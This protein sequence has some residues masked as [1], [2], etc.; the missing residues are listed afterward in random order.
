MTRPRSDGRCCG[1]LVGWMLQLGSFATRG[2]SEGRNGRDAEYSSRQ[3]HAA[4]NRA[5]LPIMS[6]LRADQTR[7]TMPAPVFLISPISRLT[8]RI[9]PSEGN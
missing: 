8:R 1:G 2:P 3:T 5:R 9:A 7:L 4:E 6:L